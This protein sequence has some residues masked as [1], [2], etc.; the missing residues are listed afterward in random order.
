MVTNKHI[1]L[2]D[3][4]SLRQKLQRKSRGRRKDLVQLAK[5]SAAPHARRN[6]PLPQLELVNVRLDDLNLPVRKT[7][8]CMPA[9]VREVMGSISE[10]GFCAP[11]LIGKDNL[12]L[13]GE[14]RI[15][16]AR[17]WVL[18]LCPASGSII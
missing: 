17:P 13:D 3:E 10:L 5:A 9:H 1:L 7:R 4:Q 14:V 2:I 8:K 6:D 11:V 18:P 16:A 15:E 12:I